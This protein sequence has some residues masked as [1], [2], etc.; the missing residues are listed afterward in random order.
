MSE[1][2]KLYGRCD[3]NERQWNLNLGS[4]EKHIWKR[5]YVLSRFYGS[6]ATLKN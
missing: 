4:R 1:G 2:I 5:D 6:Q 3:Y